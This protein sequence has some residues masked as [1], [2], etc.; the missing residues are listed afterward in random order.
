MSKINLP[1]RDE[2]TWNDKGPGFGR[3]QHSVF[4][5]LLTAGEKEGFHRVEQSVLKQ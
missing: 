3:G 2:Q 4:A 1:C 5:F